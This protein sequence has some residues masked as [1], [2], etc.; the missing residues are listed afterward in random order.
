[1]TEVAFHHVGLTVA[2]IED[3]L[4]FWRDGLRLPVTR[5]FDADEPDLGAVVGEPGARVLAAQLSVGETTRIDLYQYVTPPAGRHVAR[6]A[7]VGAMHV[8]LAC[9]DPEGLAQRLLDRG[10]TRLGEPR[11][12]GG[13]RCVYLRDPD[14]HIVELQARVVK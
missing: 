14:G 9:D 11:T 8:A 10:G 1:M 7:D 5:R 6:S 4:R 13:I 2:D 12:L 3:S